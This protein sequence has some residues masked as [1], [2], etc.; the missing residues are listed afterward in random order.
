MIERFA[1]D[2]NGGFYDTSHDHERLI[3]RPKDLYDGATPSANSVAVDV[4]LRL[5]L[6]T[7]EPSYH[8]RAMRSLEAMAPLIARA[9][10]A[11]G[12]WLC[13][14]DFALG[15]PVEVAIVGDPGDAATAA[16]LRVVR[17]PFLP[18]K[19]IAL[20]A[21]DDDEAAGRVPL[22]ADRGPVGGRPAAYVC[23]NFACRAPTADPEELARQ[24]G[25]AQLQ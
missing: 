4:L 12:R 5:A 15:E 9:P 20:R 11:F 24:L 22:L 13:G 19:V 18:N 25:L 14:L 17:G 10:Q 8:D 21:P 23:R 7:G 2:D 1:D 6:L 16:L 3:S